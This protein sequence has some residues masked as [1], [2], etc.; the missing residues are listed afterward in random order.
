MGRAV[1]LRRRFFLAFALVSVPPV[2]VLAAAV[3][4][5]VSRSADRTA[6]G[7]LQAALQGVD[8]RVRQLQ[9]RAAEHARA[10]AAEDVPR[11][12]ADPDPQAATE[13]ARRRELDVLEVIGPE[14]RIVTS[15][16]W[17]AGFG[18][19]DRDRTFRGTAALRAETVSEGYGSGE[20]LAVVAEAPARWRE[21][22]VQVR[23]GY[24]LDPRTLAELSELM[25]AEVGIRDTDADRW[26]TAAASPLR[27]WAGPAAR[28][29]GEV[30][31]SGR[32]YRWASAE[33]APTLLA[34]VAVPE[35][36]LSDVAGSVLG[37]TLAAAAVALLGAVGAALVLSRRIAE[38]VSQ[39]FDAMSGELAE[40]RERLL[41]AERVAAWREMARRLAHE[42]KNPIFPIQL[43]IE[44]L[45]RQ[46]DRD[47]ADGAAF[48]QAFRESSDTIL[49]ELGALRK[50]IDEFSQFARM[51]SPQP[52]AVDVN[53]VVARTLKLYEARAG[54]VE[55]RADLAAALPAVQADRDLLGRAISNLVA[56]AIEAMPEGGV[57]TVRTSAEPGAVRIDVEDTGP[58][59]SEEQRTRLFTPYFTTK[60]G[61]TGLGLA[62][63][64]GV[65]SDHGGRI[66]V[67]SAPGEGTAFAIRLPVG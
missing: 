44:T 45:R 40:S 59:L 16:H 63:V 58:G 42:L 49:E 54:A 36:V 9:G 65:V 25:G 67:R 6:A 37:A 66:D 51:P 56:N 13:W 17:T 28:G 48:N 11:L 22:P 29:N 7:R 24:L 18:L 30:G 26:I 38:P 34:V 12:D 4:L 53:E 52:S 8:R 50:I 46:A 19:V 47:G 43:S 10:I 35:T 23:A 57:L 5:L 15:H 33:L 60:R 55:L 62:I 14:G 2:L 21:Q 31:L 64:Q 32:T 20:Q 27:Q 41:Q 61:G 3:L 1:T 39:T